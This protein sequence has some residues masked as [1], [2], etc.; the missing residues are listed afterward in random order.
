MLGLS[1]DETLNGA[2]LDFVNLVLAGGVQDA[3]RPYFF[4]V[5][6]HAL[7]KKDGG[8]RPIAVGMTL[9][10]FV[11]KVANRSAMLSSIGTLVPKQLWVGTRGGYE[12]RV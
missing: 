12:G 3:I 1:A 10:R 7:T 4:G 2:L 6:L 8:L 11:S 9:C 5:R